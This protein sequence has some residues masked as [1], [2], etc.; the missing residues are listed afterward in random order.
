MN[1]A[2]NATHTI[3]IGRRTSERYGYK[4]TDD[5]HGERRVQVATVE[6]DVVLYIDVR[7]LE[8]YAVRA[9]TNRNGQCRVAGGAI[10]FQA[11][12][13]KETKTHGA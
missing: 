2:K 1:A 8:G 4:K 10:L 7:A 12:Q 11:L 6:G 9:L 5:G 3:K 13:R